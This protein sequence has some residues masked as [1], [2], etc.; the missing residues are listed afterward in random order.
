MPMAIIFVMSAMSF[1]QRR[2]VGIRLI[3]VFVIGSRMPFCWLFMVSGTYCG[4]LTINLL[5]KFID[6]IHLLSLTYS[7]YNVHIWHIMKKW[8]TPNVTISFTH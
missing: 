1:Q 5:R 3:V 7:F 8:F 4:M 2:A 6:L